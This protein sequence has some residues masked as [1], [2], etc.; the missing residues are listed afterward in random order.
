MR[1]LYLHRH[2]QTIG[3]SLQSLLHVLYVPD[4]CFPFPLCFYSAKSIFP[5]TKDCSFIRAS[6][7]ATLL[8][9]PRVT[10]QTGPLTRALAL[11][12]PEG[13]PLLVDLIQ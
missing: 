8:C 13:A 7:F 10:K 4:R 5:L 6:I 11:H 1:V 3:G 12:L 9:H 2:P